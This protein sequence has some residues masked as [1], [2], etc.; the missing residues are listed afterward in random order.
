MSHIVI[1]DDDNDDRD[2]F[3]EIVKAINSS[4]HCLTYKDAEHALRSLKSFDYA[5]PSL[6]FLDLNMPKMNGIQCLTELKSDPELRK[7][8]VIIYSTGSADRDVFS[9]LQLG[10]INYVIKPSRY[11]KTVDAI[12]FFLKS[13]NLIPGTMTD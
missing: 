4:I 7:I 3:C 10:A 5:L 1:I 12:R 9:A 2:I 6:I 8:P 13:Y 11:Q